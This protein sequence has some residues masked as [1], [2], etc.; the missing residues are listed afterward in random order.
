MSAGYF[1][2]FAPQVK[3]VLSTGEVHQFESVAWDWGVYPPEGKQ[4]SPWLAEQLRQVMRNGV[5]GLTEITKAEYDE[6]IAKK[7]AEPDG[8]SQPWREEFK[9]D[10]SLEKY[11]AQQ[12][13]QKRQSTPATVH[14]VPPAAAGAEVSMQGQARMAV[15]PAAPVP[16]YQ[17]S[18]AAGQ[19]GGP[20]S[21]GA[22][23][24]PP[25]ALPRPTA[26]KPK[27]PKKQ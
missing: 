11:Q 22:V 13:E 4:M 23:P 19:A 24:T 16:G 10:I 6:L 21:A 25:P 5:G 1:K 14:L 12:A 26:S 9:M 15:P 7:K 3:V 17:T 27:V 8:M 2:K 20:G 18:G